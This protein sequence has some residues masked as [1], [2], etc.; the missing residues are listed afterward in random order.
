MLNL[1]KPPH[2]CGTCHNAKTAATDQGIQLEIIMGGDIFYSGYI[3]HLS[4]I[5]MLCPLVLAA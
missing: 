2:L 4:E 1:G 5:M 3:L